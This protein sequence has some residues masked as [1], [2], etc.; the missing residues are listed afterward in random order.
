M[1][2]VTEEEV[3][4]RDDRWLSAALIVE[5]PYDLSPYFQCYCN[6]LPERPI[7]TGI[8]E[9]EPLLNMRGNKVLSYCL[10]TNIGKLRVIKMAE[11]MVLAPFEDGDISTA[12]GRSAFLKTALICIPLDWER[13]VEHA[14]HIETAGAVGT[15]MLREMS[16]PK[17]ICLQARFSH[18]S[19]GLNEPEGFCFL[20]R[21]EDRSEL[22]LTISHSGAILTTPE[23]PF[24]IIASKSKKDTERALADFRTRIR[25]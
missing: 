4:E 10:E 23:P 17:P 15:A 6:V 7:I 16:K 2:K 13:S 9:A 1:S 12:Q 19:M 20:F 5:D 22:F 3:I 21:V 25:K 18:P 8:Q 24:E 11:G 14:G